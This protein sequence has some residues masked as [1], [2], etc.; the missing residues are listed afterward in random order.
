MTVEDFVHDGSLRLPQ[1]LKVLLDSNGVEVSSITVPLGNTV[2]E[3]IWEGSDSGELSVKGAYNFYREK[4]IV[5]QWQK[6]KLAPVY[7]AQN[8]CLHLEM[9]PQQPSNR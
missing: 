2:D 5:I 4:A 3:I 7:I 6:K 8:Q 9:R 1:Q